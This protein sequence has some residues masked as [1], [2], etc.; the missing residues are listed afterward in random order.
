MKTKP[1][2]V[3]LL[4]VVSSAL[5]LTWT[6]LEYSS[7]TRHDSD[8]WAVLQDV[9]GTLL[10]VEPTSDGVWH[11]L[12]ALHANGSR[13]WVGGVVQRYENKWGFRFAPE[14]I[15]V[16]QA[17]IEGAQATIRY[18][19]ENLEYWLTFGIAYVGAVVLEVHEP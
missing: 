10:A 19:S 9:E 2:L 1:V 13:M 7:A 17:T 18:I 11:H 4:V 15:I 16:A 14:T 6:H 3:A 8:R 5:V 12:V